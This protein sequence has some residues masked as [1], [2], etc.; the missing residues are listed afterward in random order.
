[1]AYGGCILP[2]RVSNAGWQPQSGTGVP[3]DMHQPILPAATGAC[4]VVHAQDGIERAM[5]SSS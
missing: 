3:P 2:S 4:V 5:S 1:M